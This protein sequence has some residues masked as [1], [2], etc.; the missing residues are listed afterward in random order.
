[1]VQWETGFQ[2]LSEILVRMGRELEG[3]VQFGGQR[4]ELCGALVEEELRCWRV[5]VDF[6][7]RRRFTA[8]G[9]GARGVASAVRS[10]RSLHSRAGRTR[11]FRIF[12]FV[13]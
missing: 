2:M 6:F 7:V 12:G 1:M 9:L 13:D 8:L 11:Q 5:V 10:V 3:C 4:K